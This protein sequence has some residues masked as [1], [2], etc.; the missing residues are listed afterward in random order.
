MVSTLVW[1]ITIGATIALAGLLILGMSFAARR[2][3]DDPGRIT[4]IGSL[5]VGGWLLAVF[6]LGASDVFASTPNTRFPLIALGISLPLAAG[7]AA[8]FSWERVR[9]LTGAVPLPWMIGV[10]LYRVA[11]AVFLIAMVGGSVPE[12]FALPAGVGDVLVGVTAPAVGYAVYKGF[13]SWRSL[14]TAWNFVGIA[15]LVLAVSTGFLTSPSA[16]QALSTNAPNYPIT[17]FPLVLIPTF[18][19]PVSIL[20]HFFALKHPDARSVP[21]RQNPGRVQLA[22]R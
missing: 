2:A 14:A 10:Q 21:S 6:V 12:E 7:L 17:R 16:F 18:A 4:A 20:L 15:D 11:G 5:V 13:R 3:L 19:V 1:V 9:E 22:R 8:W